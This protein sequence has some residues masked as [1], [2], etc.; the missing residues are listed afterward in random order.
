MIIPALANMRRYRRHRH[1]RYTVRQRRQ[2]SVKQINYRVFRCTGAFK[3]VLI[4]ER[5][6][7][8]SALANAPRPRKW[9]TA[10]AAQ[11]VPR[12]RLSARDAAAI[13]IIYDV[14]FTIIT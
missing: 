6:K 2:Y 4:D 9:N 1:D 5:L 3:L 8:I 12:R 10:A 14:I 11:S 13:S 7:H